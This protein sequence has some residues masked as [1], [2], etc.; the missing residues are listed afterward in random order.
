MLYCVKAGAAALIIA[1]RPGPIINVPFFVGQLLR[2]FIFVAEGV[3]EQHHVKSF[4]RAAPGRAHFERS[5]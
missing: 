2:Q 4:A 3:I 5:R 1:V